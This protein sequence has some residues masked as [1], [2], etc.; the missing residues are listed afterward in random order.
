M[1]FTST[2]VRLQFRLMLLSILFFVFHASIAHSQ[3]AL[4]VAATAASSRQNDGL[5]PQNLISSNGLVPDAT[6]PAI[7]RLLAYAPMYTSSY[8]TPNDETPLV[9][10][11]FGAKQT[12]NRFHVWNANEPGYVFR[13]FRSVTIQYSD[14]AQRW[15]SVPERFV[16]ERAPG[17]DSYEGQ[18]IAL[19]RPITARFIRFVCNN[20]WRG[21]GDSDVAAL[22]RVQFF[23]GGVPTASPP[24]TLPWPL[25]S[26]VV[27]VTKAPYFAKGDGQ[28]D[29]T[30]ALQQAILD[31]EGTRRTIY[32]REGTYLISAPLKF[33]ENSSTNRNGLFGRNT[34]RGENIQDTVIRLKDA[35]LTD[36]SKPQAVLA[37]GYISFFAE[38][39]EQTSGDWFH[40]NVSDLTIDIGRGNPGAKGME[41]FSNNTGSVRNVQIISR[42]GQGRI[43]LD[44]GH[45][46]KN[47]PLLVKGLVVK[48]FEVGVRAGFTVNSLTF[49]SLRLVGQTVSA[50]D[51]DGQSISVK[52]LATFGQVP[53]LR[54]RYGTV[55]LINATFSGSGRAASEAAITNG[56]NLFARNVR[57]TGFAQTIKNNYGSS[58]NVVGNIAGDYVSSGAALTLFGGQTDSLNLNIQ[59]TP[60][61]ED[62]SADAW[63]NVRD[64]RLT[65][66][67]N[68]APAFQRAIDSGARDVYLPTDARIVLKSDVFVRGRVEI[69]HGMQANVIATSGVKI[70]VTDA[71]ESRIVM[72]EQFYV[73]A[74]D[75]SP[76]FVNESTKRF[77]LLD[78]EAGV[79]GA[80]SGAIFMENVTGKFEFGNHKTWARQVNSEP[81]GVKISNK[82]G[83]LWVLGLKTERA[84]TLV[85][86]SDGG[87]TE[88]IGGLCYTTTAGTDPM[89]TVDNASLSATIGEIAYNNPPYSVLVRETRAGVTRELLRGQAPIRFSFLGGSALPLFVSKP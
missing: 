26:G 6:N 19:P 36:A 64:F 70:R 52:G 3:D 88:I 86:T 80:G 31:H 49:E 34:L 56:E 57:S 22:G 71:L 13:G 79:R 81:S 50:F 62:D 44:L 12:I 84:G 35:T 85:A 89:F 53:G 76:L 59:D 27:D 66:E 45:Q 21:G 72:A 51:N 68:D 82:G 7:K 42:D 65:T 54:N 43:G 14:D 24:E 63:R 61:F 73:V 4:L 40:N 17:A 46:D 75:N 87:A 83:S 5:G 33:S 78:S 16:F 15:T 1:K 58:A 10:F 38:N 55:A 29:D 9:H 60:T 28:T 67:D 48:G 41:F 69:I 23:A 77:V 18:T 74:A 2:T 30:K 20:T 32:L 11:Y 8:G 25:A 47:G 37:T 39:R